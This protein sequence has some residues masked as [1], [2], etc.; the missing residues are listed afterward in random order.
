MK[1]GVRKPSIRG[2]ISSRTSLKRIARHSLGWKAP[3]GAG[4][5]TNPK[6]AL[7]NRVYN[8]ASIS[9]DRLLSSGSRRRSEP[10]D[11][12][13]GLASASLTPSPS[14]AASPDEDILQYRCAAC[15]AIVLDTASGPPQVKC[16]SCGARIE[17]SSTQDIEGIHTTRV[18]ARSSWTCAVLAIVATAVCLM[19]ALSLLS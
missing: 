7:Y 4:W 11:G 19:V 14:P 2:R 18:L 17:V 12:H 9:V 1:F 8:R 10:S 6:K 3:R 15:G 16:S 5:I 13:E